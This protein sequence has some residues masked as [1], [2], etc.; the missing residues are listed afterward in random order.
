MYEDKSASLTIDDIEDIKTF[1]PHTNRISNGYSSSAFWITFQII[2]KTSSSLEYYLKFTENFTDKLDYYIVSEDGSYE[3]YNEG[4]GYFSKDKTN[5]LKKPIFPIT[6]LANETKTIYFRMSSIFPSMTSFYVLNSSALHNYILKHDTLYALYF[7]A[8]I[9]LILY[10]IFI[11]FFSRNIAYLYYILYATPFLFWQMRLNGAFPFDTFSTT[12][13]YYLHGML[14]PFFIAFIIFFS[15]EVLD[16]K[17]LFPKS[18]RVIIALGFLYIL[19]TFTA[20]FDIHNSTYIAT[21]LLPIVLPFLLIMGFRS[22]LKGNKTALFYIIA[23]LI[24]LTTSIMFSMTVNGHLEYTFVSRHGL[25]LGSF[26]EMILFS[27][28]LAYKIRELEKE[29]LTIIDQANAE[30]DSKIKE[31]T[32]ELEESKDKLKEIANRDFMTNLYNRRSFFNISQELLSTAKREN[33]P[34]S[35]IMF[36]ID[37]F[38][39]VNDTYGHATGDRVITLFASLIEQTRESDIAARI[40][41]EEFVLL[42]PN[43]DEGEAY[44]IASTIRELAEKQRLFIDEKN[45]LEYTVSGGISSV[46]LQEDTDIHQTLHRAD[47]NLYKA[48]K[49]G[50]N[51]IYPYVHL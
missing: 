30:L 3:K 37:K 12:S 1:S 13:S 8:I 32:R 9:A 7:G 19:F 42:L 10:N 27:L 50:R 40:G 51:L 2:N 22:Y 38:K 31:R 35:I 24:F 29:K 17:K 47:E 46:N 11:L 48:K 36:D 14:T 20:I 39:D 26:I 15:R 28:A 45:F 34:L 41:G 33:R 43:T 5:I 6:L 25:V 21:K 49:N 4:P 18:D 44:E 16:T 23:Q